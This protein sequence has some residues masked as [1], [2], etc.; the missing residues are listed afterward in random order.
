MAVFSSGLWKIPYNQIDN[1]YENHPGFS[2]PPP[3]FVY[4]FARV[5]IH[6]ISAHQSPLKNQAMRKLMF[7]MS[8]L[9][10]YTCFV[11]KFT[12][13]IVRSFFTPSSIGI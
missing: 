10:G 1:G 13:N 9:V 11:M 5:W 12:N 3:P 6:H 4:D 2:H 7:S 8:L